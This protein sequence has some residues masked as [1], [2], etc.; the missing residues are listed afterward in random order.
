MQLSGGLASASTTTAVHLLGAA[1]RSGETTAWI[2]A[3]G[4][5]L[6]PPDLAE[7]GID[8][9]ALVVL[10]IPVL[11]T[12]PTPVKLAPAKLAPAKIGRAPASSRATTATTTTT[13]TTMV[14]KTN[15][16]ATSSSSTHG[17]CRAA[18]IL[19]RSGAF[20]F[21]VLDLSSPGSVPRDNTWQS[22]LAALCRQHRARLLILTALPP[23][24]LA[25]VVRP[26]ATTTPHRSIESQLD[27]GAGPNSPDPNSPEE[28]SPASLG[29]MIR[30]HLAPVRTTL[31]DGQFVVQHPILKNKSGA[32]VQ[33]A[34][35]QYRGPWGLR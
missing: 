12:A 10:H 28:Q 27:R 16:G 30:F 22:R 14:A 3:E 17:L 19:L 11:A 8:L 15:H 26:G 23:A 34:D 1:Q 5:S 24:R 29:P 6:F 21:V 7:S 31:P 35:A 4:G 13:T 20:G 33:I 25:R 32:P 9:D 2:Q 18:E